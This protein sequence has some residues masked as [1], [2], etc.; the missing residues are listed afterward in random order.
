MSTI[1]VVFIGLGIG[2]IL[3]FLVKR[4]IKKLPDI[5]D[6]QFIKKFLAVYGGVTSEV[7]I[8]ERDYLASQLGIACN[9]LDPNYTFDDLSK[10]LEDHFG[11]YS[12]AI[13]DIESSVSE[14]FEKL[15]V[16]K[17]YKSP[18]T[19]GELIYEIVKAKATNSPDSL[20]KK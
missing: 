2:L 14:L 9:K 3:I 16:K 7:I 1:I 15:G 11:S 17:P 8:R 4:R 19:I 10:H 13:G 20:S 18:A 12:L 6:E 5:N